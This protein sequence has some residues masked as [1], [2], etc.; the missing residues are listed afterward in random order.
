[1]LTTPY[2]PPPPRPRPTRIVAAKVEPWAWGG[3]HEKAASWIMSA[4]SK[5]LAMTGSTGRVETYRLRPAGSGHA[6]RLFQVDR[7]LDDGAWALLGT[8]TVTD[9]LG[10]HSE[11]S[12]WEAQGRYKAAF[13]RPR[14]SDKSCETDPAFKGFTWLWARLWNGQSLSAAA[15]HAVPLQT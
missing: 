4:G 6:D 14:G 11:P 15:I 3:D 10:R 7:R 2:I 9:G 13:C 1:M 5:S 12:E 8:A